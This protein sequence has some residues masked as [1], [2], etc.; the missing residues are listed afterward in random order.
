MKVHRFPFLKRTVITYN[1]DDFTGDGPSS[2]LDINTP[3]VNIKEG[4]NFILYYPKPICTQ[5]LSRNV[6]RNGTFP[7]TI[8]GIDVRVQK[9]SCNDC[10]YSFDA[11]HPNYGYGKHYSDDMND[12]TVKG[13]VKTS[14]RKTKSFFLDLLGMGISHETIRTNVPDVPT[15]K[16]ESSGYF[17][18]DEQYVSIDGE[19]RYRTLLRDAKNGNFIEDVINDLDE[20]SLI[21]F[22][23][24]ALSRFSIPSTI[25]ITTDGFH[26]ESVLMEVSRRMGITMKRQRC[27]FHLEKDLAHKI[28]EQHREKELDLAKRFIKFMFF[29][30]DRNIKKIGG[31]S[32]LLFRNIE[33]ISESDVV[34][35]II[36]LLNAYYGDDPII[37]KFLSF[38][39]DNRK[40]VFLYLEYPLVEKTTGIA[41]HHF[42]IMSWLLKNRFKT[43]EGLL[44]TSYWYH[45][46]L[47]TQI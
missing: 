31:Y 7:R 18:Y 26:Y 19:R 40:E 15:E 5:C 33:D 35:H 9:Y 45:H 47:S 8:G 34:E 27:L 25:Y 4:K 23:M 21:T 24:N 1:L 17:V 16:M 14:L 22:L 30:T 44:K 37:S 6:S 11:R 39:Q 20:S 28:R 13:R 3:D 42:S 32:D 12:K 2:P 10:G 41:E 29:Q 38:I 46:Y 36:H 43:K